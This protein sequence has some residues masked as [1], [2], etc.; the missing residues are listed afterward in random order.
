MLERFLLVGSLENGLDSVGNGTADPICVPGG[1][2]RG[3]G[4]FV[5]EETSESSHVAHLI[6]FLHATSTRAGGGGGGGGVSG[7]A[8]ANHLI[9]EWF[10]RGEVSL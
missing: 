1:S 2:G 9:R 5:L 7:V 10:K 3:I 4:V 8:C 6:F